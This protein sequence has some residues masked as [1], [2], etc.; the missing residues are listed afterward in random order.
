MSHCFL[1]NKSHKKG[2]QILRKFYSEVEL[3][4]LYSILNL[5][6]LEID[7][8]KKCPWGK[9][10]ISAITKHQIIDLFKLRQNNSFQNR[11][12]FSSQLET[13]SQDEKRREVRFRYPWVLN[14]VPSLTSCVILASF[15]ANKP[16]FLF[17]VLT[18][19]KEHV[20][21]VSNIVIQYKIG[22]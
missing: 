18:F 5:Y 4:D 12:K 21:Q 7:V 16:Q 19:F 13:E 17:N 3:V 14:S 2:V 9:K 10:W 8:R 20:Y 6:F 15:Q 11:I 22:I 1:I